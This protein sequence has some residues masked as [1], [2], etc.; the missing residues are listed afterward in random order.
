MASHLDEGLDIE[1]AKHKHRE[2]AL[3]AAGDSMKLDG[4]M[5]RPSKLRVVPSLT[6]PSKPAS[7]GHPSYEDV[8]TERVSGRRW[9]KPHT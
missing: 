9:K 4:D 7:S 5:A 1:R 2:V 3:V 8:I 6:D